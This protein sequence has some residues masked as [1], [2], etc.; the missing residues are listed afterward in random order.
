MD[1]ALLH[2]HYLRV[3]G[4]RRPRGCFEFA[5]AIDIA[6]QLDDGGRECL[7]LVGQGSHYEIWDLEQWKQQLE[8]LR[9]GGGTSLPPGMENFSL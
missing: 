7:R 2:L 3:A 8:N 1:F 5:P 9:S 4:V 6:K